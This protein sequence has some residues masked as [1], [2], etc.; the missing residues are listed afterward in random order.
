MST[1][2]DKATRQRL[3]ERG[4]K[5]KL[6]LE[7]PLIHEVTADLFNEYAQ[8]FLNSAPDDPKREQAYW[9]AQGL[10]DLGGTLTSYQ[11]VGEQVEALIRAEDAEGAQEGLN[12]DD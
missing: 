5:A 10:K 6:F 9:Q 3:I 1:T 11:Q 12:T 2:D 8:T 4:V 7:H